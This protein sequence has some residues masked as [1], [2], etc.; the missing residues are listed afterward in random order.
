MELNS[1]PL[2][3]RKKRFDNF[4]S[5]A[6]YI[7]NNFSRTSIPSLFFLISAGIVIPFSSADCERSFSDLN[8]IKSKER[9]KT[10]EELLRDLMLIYTM[11]VEEMRNLKREK[12]RE[13]SKKLAH[14]VWSRLGYKL[15]PDK[16]FNNI[17]IV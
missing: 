4:R 8:R 13:M 6:K 15:K 14:K 1:H 2:R 12:L 3:L 16:Y 7:L 10:G 17:F 5:M 9:S 11:S